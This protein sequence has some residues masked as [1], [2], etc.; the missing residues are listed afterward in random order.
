MTDPTAASPTPL[1]AIVLAAGQ[2]TRMKSGLPKVL[3]AVAGRPMISHVLDRLS[4]IGCRPIVPV[5]GPAMSAVERAVRPW[6]VAVQEVPRGTGDAARAAAALLAGFAGDVL[7]AYGDAPLIGAATLQLLIAR[8]RAADRPDLALLAMRPADPAEYG[9]VIL[10]PDGSVAAI[11]EFRDAGPAERAVDLC[12]SGVMVVDGAR[13]FGWLAEIG[14]ANAKGEFYLTDIVAIARRHGARCAHEVGPASELLGINSRAELAAAEAVMQD[15]LRQAAMAG[16]ATLVDPASVFLAAD[17]RLGR[18]VTVGPW[19]QFGPG[20]TVADEVEIRAFCHVEGATIERGAVI[21][22]FARLR[23]GS[24][25]GEGARVGNFVETK[26]ARL[27]AGAKANHLSYLG[28]AEIG[29]K[30]NIGAGTI[31]CNYDGFD[32]SRT[33]IGAGAFI[34]SNSALVAPVTIGEGAIVG[35]G[36]VVTEDVAADS[37]VIARAPQVEKPRWASR[38]RLW[39]RN[40]AASRKAGGT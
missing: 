10:D 24:R 31:T 33:V 7:I 23:S 32:K 28:D 38:F 4:E 37:L 9:R 13:L 3:H 26:N 1:A 19:V 34:G 18:D 21:G 6:P 15:R 35:A 20:V 25:I 11:V 5:I 17:T 14:N 8:R 16:G 2:G 12:N 36:S 30:A 40:A 29:A 39:K 22:P 27:A